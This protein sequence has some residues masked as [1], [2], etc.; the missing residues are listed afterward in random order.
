[1]TVK[2]MFVCLGN[3]CRSPTAH[4]VFAAMVQDAGLSDQILVDSCGTSG[5]HIGNP[6]DE[7]SVAMA[8]ERGFDL[9]VL[10][11]SQIQVQDFETFDFVLA[12]D[13]QNLS[14]LQTV[15]PA[16]YSGQLDLLLNFDPYSDV[17]EV[18]DPYY[19][20]EEGFVLA[21]ELIEAACLQLLKH[22]KATL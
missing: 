3:I 21:V 5:W 13:A 11:A 1:M 19:G 10:R 14:D 20:G 9:S 15:A 22:I 6:P 4:G 16:D 8:A 17:S 18:P 2:V 12:M 7:R